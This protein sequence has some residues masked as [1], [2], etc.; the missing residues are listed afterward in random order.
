MLDL[1]ELFAPASS[2]SGRISMVCS[3]A[4]DLNP[5]TDSD[6]IASESSRPGVVAIG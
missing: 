1:P 4:I 2:V 6:V 5:A 3:W